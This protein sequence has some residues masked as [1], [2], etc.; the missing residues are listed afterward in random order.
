MNARARRLAARAL[1][2]V[3]LLLVI[4]FAAA[5][6]IVPRVLGL[7]PLRLV[8]NSMADSG[9]HLGAGA[10]V[11]VDPRVEPED[12]RPGDIISFS[13]PHLG[14][15]DGST[16]TTHRIVSIG[17]SDE[18]RRWGEDKKLEPGG[19]ELVTR[20]DSNSAADLLPVNYR[21]VVGR[22]AYSLPWVGHVAAFNEW[23]WG[24]IRSIL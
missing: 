16:L 12:L 14:G 23:L 15:A 10:I 20:G 3:A 5:T 9:P 22:V 7:E 13:T 19:L 17:T 18:L 8:S 24:S 21:Y 11:Y 6:T 1:W 2:L 4:A